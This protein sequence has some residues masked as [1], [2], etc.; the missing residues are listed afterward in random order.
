[1]T[2][3][4]NELASQQSVPTQEKIK[5]CHMLIYYAHTYPNETM[6]YCDSNMCLHIYSDMAYLVQP[7]E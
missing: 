1:M 5:K 4:V 2:V 3:A 7:Q 6:I